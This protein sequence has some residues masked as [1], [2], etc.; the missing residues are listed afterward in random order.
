MPSC[1]LSPGRA[2]LH[3][4]HAHLLSG[5][6]LCTAQ[7]P[8]LFFHSVVQ[9]LLNSAVNTQHLGAPAAGSA[10]AKSDRVPASPHRA[11]PLLGGVCVT[12]R[13]TPSRDRE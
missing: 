1:S 9:P 3:P 13:G 8:H 4:A 11:H 2:C 6:G 10:L 7:S 12:G 5:P